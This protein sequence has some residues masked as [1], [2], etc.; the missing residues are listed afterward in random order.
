MAE[1][2]KAT[3]VG[4]DELV[5]LEHLL[6]RKGS[7]ALP[8]SARRVI[9][10]LVDG[11]RDG[12]V[13]VVARTGQLITTTQ[14]AAILGVSRPRVAQLIMRRVLS[15]QLVGSHHRLL[16]PEVLDLKRQR[17][18]LEGMREQMYDEDH[19]LGL[20]EGGI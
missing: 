8:K 20:P 13:V 15:T 9:S 17:D 1:I 10:A 2:I 5:S 18:A 3:D 12:D 4:G 7:S 16:L 14:A 6:S 19:P 11:V